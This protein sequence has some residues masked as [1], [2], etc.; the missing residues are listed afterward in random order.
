M[1]YIDE[2]SRLEFHKSN[3]LLQMV[4]QIFESFCFI[5][6][7]MPE[8]IE[9]LDEDTALL[10]LPNAEEAQAEDLMQKINS[11]FLRIDGALTCSMMDK[12][13]GL[14]RIFVTKPGDLLYV[15]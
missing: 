11:Q 4:C 12:E 14:F 6:G 9:L 8:F 10:G 3:S 2:E 15:N 13:W 7:L 5:Q 1:T